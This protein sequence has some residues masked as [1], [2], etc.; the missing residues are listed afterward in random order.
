MGKRRQGDSMTRAAVFLDR[1]GVLNRSF[2]HGGK[3][4]PP[5]TLAEFEILPEVEGAARR[6]KEEGFA[7]VVATNQ[8]DV[9]K[10]TQCREVIEAMHEQLRGRLP[11]DAIKVC[12]CV[13][14]PACE[15]YKPKPG[16]LLQAAAELGLDLGRSFMVGDR[17]RDVGAGRNAGCFTIFIDRGYNETL[18]D[19]PDAV[20]R[21]LAEAVG[22]ILAQSRGAAA[23]RKGVPP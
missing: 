19:T 20:C 17:W 5:Q 16:M 23:R 21:D 4:F 7:L 12:W 18:R 9:A 11:L 10:G 3:P 8:P 14:G 2:V 22:V 1:D 15:C 6:L 13:E